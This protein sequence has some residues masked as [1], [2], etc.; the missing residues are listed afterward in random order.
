MLTITANASG[1]GNQTI[2]YTVAASPT[3]STRT[4]KITVKATGVADQVLTVTQTGMA[5]LF[6]IN[7][8]PANTCAAS[9]SFPVTLTCVLDGSGSVGAITT[10]T[11]TVP[12]KGNETLGTPGSNPVLTNPTSVNCG[13]VINQM[14]HFTLTVTSTT[15]ETAFVTLPFTT[16]T[17]SG[18]LAPEVNKR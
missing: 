9:G 8:P 15:S 2:T 3:K 12:D 17:G 5:A 13:Y 11:Y 16:T 10:Y 7:G 4:P 6:T 1:T 14:F 18:C